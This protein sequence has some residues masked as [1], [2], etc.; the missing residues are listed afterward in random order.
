[1]ENQSNG[2]FEF[3]FE[4][5]HRS[6]GDHA[7]QKHFLKQKFQAHAKTLN[8]DF[9]AFEIVDETS[10]AA[11]HEL[12]S[13]YNTLKAKF[14]A[15]AL[16]REKLIKRE[17][18]N[19]TEI[20]R[21]LHLNAELEEGRAA[22]EVKSQANLQ[23]LNKWK[24]Q[25]NMLLNKSKQT[26]SSHRSFIESI[27]DHLGIDRNMDVNEVVRILQKGDHK[28]SKDSEALIA[29][30]KIQITR[31]E[32]ELLAERAKPSPDT[33]THETVTKALQEIMELKVQLE[34]EKGQNSTQLE[35]EKSQSSSRLEQEKARNSNLVRSIN[36]YRRHS[37]RETKALME[38]LTAAYTE[39]NEVR[40]ALDVIHQTS[41]H[42][43][44]TTISISSKVERAQ[45]HTCTTVEFH[46]EEEETVSNSGSSNM[47]SNFYEQNSAEHIG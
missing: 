45:L 30:L 39:L 12:R 25:Y 26:L 22:E 7:E 11:F 6:S 13:E 27:L 10:D 33:Y 21:L 23:S 19:T 8:E 2:A 46:S 9:S 29:E 3:E 44:S 41:S 1:M 42:A 43:L 24:S 34:R 40:K 37:E 47:S 20:A 14:D 28:S 4:R 36:Q 15:M 5:E 38:Q 17:K 16:E 35:K 31:L 32:G 18:E